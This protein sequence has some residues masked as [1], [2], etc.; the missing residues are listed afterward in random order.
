MATPVSKAPLKSSETMITALAEI[1]PRTSV[2][3]VAATG[4][5][6]SLVRFR[7]FIAF[8]WGRML[9]GA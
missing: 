2:A 7:V 5:T 8:S 4:V 3:N 1:A 6:R 9:S